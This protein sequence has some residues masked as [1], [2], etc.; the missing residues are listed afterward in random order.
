MRIRQGSLEFAP[1]QRKQAVTPSR[2]TSGSFNKLHSINKAFLPLLLIVCAFASSA[3]AHSL[4]VVA[5]LS[6]TVAVIDDSTE[7][8][9]H[10]NPR[11]RR[12]GSYQYVTGSAQ[13]LRFQRHE[14]NGVGS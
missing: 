3:L 7:Q 1:G 8:N 9:H 4:F 2:S 14:R 10:Q 6:D 12:A 13:G 11:R 5:R